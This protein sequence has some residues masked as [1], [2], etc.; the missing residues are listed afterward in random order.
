MDEEIRE[1]VA[2]WKRFRALTPAHYLQLPARRLLSAGG[3]RR[4]DD[5]LV[6]YVIGLEALL[7]KAD[8]RTELAYRFRVRGAVVLA[9][10]RAER[11]ARSRALNELYSLRSRVVH[12][13]HSDESELAAAMPIAEDA[14]RRVWRWYFDHYP[15]GGTNVAGINRIDLDLLGP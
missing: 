15:S 8:E 13:M 1:F 11:R 3:R 12:G 7:G 9:L 10:T 5:A 6:D 2:F 4:T 14:L